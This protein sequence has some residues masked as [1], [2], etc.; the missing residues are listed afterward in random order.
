M[1]LT[2]FSGNPKD[3]DRWSK[4]FLAKSKIKGYKEVILGTEVVNKDGSNFLEIKKLNDL[5]HAEM[6]ICC[7]T[8][9]CFA[10]VEN[11]KSEMFADGDARLGWLNLVEKFEPKTKMNMIKLKKEFMECGLD[12]PNK[13][14]DEWLLKLEGL[15]WKLKGLGQNISEEDMMVHILHNLPREYE[16]TIEIL[17]IELENGELDLNKMRERLRNK[18]SRMETKSNQETSERALMTGNGFKTTYKKQCYTCGELGHKGFECPKRNK[19]KGGKEEE[20]NKNFEKREF[21]CYL[22]GDPSHK[23]L[24][25]P[26]H[27]NNRKEKSNFGGE[28]KGMSLI[29]SELQVET[30]GLWICDSGAS[31]HMTGSSFGMTN[32]K[33][34][35]QEVI[36]GDGR[37]L[38]AKE[39]GDLNLKDHSNGMKVT[40]KDVKVV[41]ELKVN[42][43]SVS[44]ALKNEAH[45]KS[46]DQ[47]L[48]IYK[49]DDEINFDQIIKMGNGHLMGAKLYLDVEVGMIGG[50]YKFENVMDYH[51]KLGHPS[52]EITKK[53]AA[54]N[55]I[56]LIGKVE[57]CENCILGK[58]KRTNIKKK[59]EDVASE[60]GVRFCADISWIRKSSLGNNRYWLIIE[61]EFTSMKWSFFIHRK[62]EAGRILVDFI[63]K[64][65]A[66]NPKFGS[67][68][69]MDNSGEN[70][71][72]AVAL[73]K[74]NLKVV[75]EFTA[76]YTPEQNGKVE[77]SFA[78][79][80]G[81]TRAMLNGAGFP[82]EMRE[83]LWAECAATATKLNNMLCK[84]EGKSP[85]ELFY[86]EKPNLGVNFKVF[87]EIGVKKDNSQ[88]LGDKLRNKGNLCFF[89]GYPENHPKDTFKVFDMSSDK[90]VI[91]RDVKWLN[92][93]YSEYFKGESKNNLEDTELESSDEEI[94]VEF[95]KTVP[96]KAEDKTKIEEET[97]NVRAINHGLHRRVRFKQEDESVMIMVKSDEKEE[98]KSFKQAWYNEDMND[99]KKWREAITKEL[100]CMK[101]LGVWEILEKTANLEGKKPIG[102]KWVFKIKRDGQFRARLVALGYNQIP[103]VDFFENYSPVINDCSFRVLMIVIQVMNY[104]VKSFDVETAFLNGDLKE[105][106][107]MK[108]PQGL[109]E[110]EKLEE[111]GVGVLKLRKSLYGLVQ[112]ARQWHEKFE[113]V[114]LKLGFMKNQIDPCMFLKEREDKRVY[115]CLYVDDG[116]I[117]GDEELLEESIQQLSNNFN[118]KVQEG[119]KDFLGCEIAIGN[120]VGTIKQTRIIEKLEKDWKLDIKKKVFKTPTPEGY[121]VIRPEEKDKLMEVIEQKKFRSGIG[122]LMYLVKLS[123]PELSNSVRELSKVMDKGMECHFGMLKRLISY[124]VQTKHLGMNIKPTKEWRIEAYADSDFC[125]DKESRKSVTGFVVFLNGVAVSWKSKSQM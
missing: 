49:D 71:G 74:E 14:P 53:T 55:N 65:R 66:D 122:T 89:L 48:V 30:E 79:L 97:A 94:E 117:T 108:A 24:D 35:E 41:E 113:N 38:K 9:L 103:G 22:C 63:K 36:L 73:E 80:W 15:R 11:S 110:V 45:M 29:G 120:D 43:F 1:K 18:F 84:R 115:I 96:P 46:K 21:K 23:K 119:M 85:Y 101:D 116:I 102:N 78:T 32:V 68:L 83:K 90:P 59:S 58:I 34:I 104:K 98:P 16:N 95:I 7:V 125:G 57:K 27:F 12:D 4:T 99:Q 50:G 51:K 77:R 86:N 105:T 76:P 44:C 92:K 93:T 69:R 20:K 3:W 26:F 61:D 64:G 19:E 60:P 121:K 111:K 67:Y 56:K 6:L 52:I 107:Y 42:L 118:L 31:C 2:N 88:N 25:C 39:V 124:V 123:R 81:K 10:I 82:E 100:N 54:M 37:C 112:A 114:I 72:I 13:D 109:M 106:I 28:K 17:E 8:D 5:A 91:T 62:P 40:L 87:G 70:Q 75:I 47:G 33:K